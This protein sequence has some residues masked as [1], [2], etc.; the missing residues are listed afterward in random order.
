MDLKE[1]IC[2]ELGISTGHSSDRINIFY[3][4]K[5]WCKNVR[6]RTS[7]LYLL[8]YTSTNSL[9]VWKM[10]S[11][12]LFPSMCVSKVHSFQIEGSD[13]TYY[14]YY[15]YTVH[16]C[17]I[18]WLMWKNYNDWLEKHGDL[19]SHCLWRHLGLLCY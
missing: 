11:L 18:H 2:L 5:N 12:S 10:G 3:F 14:I 16:A 13:Y 1:P 7:E 19:N 17:F 9:I 4:L 15:Y 6:M 8:A